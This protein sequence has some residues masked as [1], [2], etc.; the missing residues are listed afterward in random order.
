M[1]LDVVLVQK[2]D[3]TDVALEAPITFAGS[4]QAEVIDRVI[5]DGSPNGI[6]MPTPVSV[7]LSGIVSNTAGDSLDASLTL[8]LSNASSY[9][10]FVV[11]EG[12][13]A[14]VGSYGTGALGANGDQSYTVTLHDGTRISLD[15]SNSYG[16]V[17]LSQT[18]PDGYRYIGYRGYAPSLL[19]AVDTYGS[20]FN[21]LYYGTHEVEGEGEYQLQWFDPIGRDELGAAIGLNSGDVYGW[22]LSPQL[23]DSLDNHALFN[24]G[25]SFEAQLT[26]LPAATITLTGDRSG[27]DSGSASMAIAYGDRS[28]DMS[29]AA[30]SGVV[31]GN[32]IITN[33][34]GLILT[35]APNS[36]GTAGE[37]S[38]N[39]EVYGAIFDTPMGLKIVYS[40]G[41]FEFL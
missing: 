12:A 10:P 19:D 29:V 40:D 26:G 39:G 41:S 37:I 24:L 33:Q 14:V 22:M 27:F 9:I 13:A 25:F 6:H 17:Y 5:A 36:A 7:S 28:L 21:E 23:A 4:L 1:D 3:V 2:R 8:N 18:Y 15:W 16:D 32:V 11:P 31:S 38:Y 35:L 34:D 20:V 30:T